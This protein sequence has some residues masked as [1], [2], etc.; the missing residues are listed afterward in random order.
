MIAPLGVRKMS[1]SRQINRIE[2]ARVGKDFLV[3]GYL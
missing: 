1:H 3:T 2:V